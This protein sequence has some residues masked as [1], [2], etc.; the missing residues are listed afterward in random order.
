[1]IDDNTPDNQE[2]DE[3][4]PT[5]RSVSQNSVETDDSGWLTSYA[6]LM[7]LVACFFILMVSFASFDDSTF[8]R[9][10][11]LMAKYYHGENDDSESKMKKLMLELNAISNMENVLKIEHSDQGLTIDMNVKTL[12]PRGRANL[13]E[14]SG[15]LIDLIID[16]VVELKG[17]VKVIVEGHTDNIPI[18][19]RYYPSNWELSS[20]RSSSVIRKFE[21]RSFDRNQLVAVGFADT[22]PAYA[23]VDKQ[24]VPIEENRLRNRRIVIKVLHRTDNAVPMGLGILFNSK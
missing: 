9:K 15:K 14:S 5:N 22:R 1:M 3:A 7:T 13:T 19:S 18:N 20:A 17:D 24:G 21:D 8:Q 12:F 16:K 10:A 2:E 4:L 6:D 23:N 11:E